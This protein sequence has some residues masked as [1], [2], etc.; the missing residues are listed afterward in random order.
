MHYCSM[1]LAMSRT[2]AGLLVRAVHRYPDI[3]YGTGQAHE[4][5]IDNPL[6]APHGE[7]AFITLAALFGVC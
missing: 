7:M 5:G 2:V 3:P 4:S 6:F 1:L